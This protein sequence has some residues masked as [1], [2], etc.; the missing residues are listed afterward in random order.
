MKAVVRQLTQQNIDDVAGRSRLLAS[1]QFKKEAAAPEVPVTVRIVDIFGAPAR[2]LPIA[3]TGNGR[4]IPVQSRSQW[5][6]T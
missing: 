3:L 4:A 6:S 1:Q 5:P 2:A